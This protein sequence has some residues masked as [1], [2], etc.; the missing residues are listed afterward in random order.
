MIHSTEKRQNLGLFPSTPSRSMPKLPKL[1]CLPDPGTRHYKNQYQD[2]TQHT[3]LSRGKD[4][5]SIKNNARAYE[6]LQK[7]AINLRVPKNEILSK[8]SNN[9]EWEI[10]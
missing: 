1:I 9:L 5:P 6:P 10:L 4:S 3:G 2:N 8:E 7:S